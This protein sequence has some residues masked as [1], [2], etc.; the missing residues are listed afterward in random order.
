MKKYE[1]EC[2]IDNGKIKKPCDL[3]KTWLE[4]EI[5]LLK[6]NQTISEI[7]QQLIKDCDKFSYYSS[8]RVNTE[9]IFMLI[10]K[11]YQSFK[12]HDID[13]KLIYNSNIKEL[14]PNIYHKD[15][16]NMLR[17]INFPHIY[18]IG[19]LYSDSISKD[20]IDII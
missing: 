11:I 16:Y 13:F 18:V 10:H 1:C 5:Y 12:N 15:I 8:D 2:K 14:I 19:L 9:R 3:H 7:C 6:N 17:I 4:N 20:I